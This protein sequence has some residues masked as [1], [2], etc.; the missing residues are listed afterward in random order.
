MGGP[1]SA[2]AP[3]SSSNE[4][5]PTFNSIRAMLDEVSHAVPSDEQPPVI[6]D[7]FS[8]VNAPLTKAF[9]WCGWQAVTPI[10]LEIDVELDVT[11]PSVLRSRRPLCMCSHKLPSFQPPCH[12]LPNLIRAR[13]KRPGPLPLRSEKFPR[14]LPTLSPKDL[15]IELTLTT[16]LPTLLW[17]F[18]NGVTSSTCCLRVRTH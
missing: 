14:G 18:R 15:K 9:L 2:V 12:V 1:L 16:Q 10:D 3:D 5:P 4:L 17:P 11:S 13:E 6:L 7:L 8:G